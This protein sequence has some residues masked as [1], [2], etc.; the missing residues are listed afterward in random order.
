MK[1]KLSEI[2][3][4]IANLGNSD[5]DPN[6]N[7]S[8]PDTSQLAADAPTRE[9]SKSEINDSLFTSR[10]QCPLDN[11]LNMD[12]FGHQVTHTFS[13]SVICDALNT[14]SYLVMIIAYMYSAI[15]VSR[16]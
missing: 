10:S 6:N 16:S 13:Y 2:S 15:I 4:K 5:N 11:E 3:D 8:D 14:L 1:T 7:N 9:I 12:F